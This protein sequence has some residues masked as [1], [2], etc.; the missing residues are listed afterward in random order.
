MYGGNKAE[1]ERTARL[2]QYFHNKLN[3][4]SIYSLGPPKQAEPVNLI[5]NR[6]LPLVYGCRITIFLLMMNFLPYIV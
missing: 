4:G 3:L 1:I 6:D 2:I 5:D